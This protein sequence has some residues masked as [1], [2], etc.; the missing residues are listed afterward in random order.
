MSQYPLDIVSKIGVCQRHQGKNNKRP[1]NN[2]SGG[3]QN[4][5]DRNDTDDNFK[6]SQWSNMRYVAGYLVLHHPKIAEA[7]DTK[8]SQDPVRYGDSVFG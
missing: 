5:D 2:S 8:K 4:Q 6:M 7:N 3:I 1:T